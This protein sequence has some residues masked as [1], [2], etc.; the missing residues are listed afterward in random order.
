MGASLST[1]DDP[2]TK[3]DMEKFSKE[4]EANPMFGRSV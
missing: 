3:A 4:Y 1:L 2:M